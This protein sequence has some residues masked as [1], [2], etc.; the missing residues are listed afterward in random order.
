M[1]KLTEQRYGKA[2]VRVLY[3]PNHLKVHAKTALLK[4]KQG[5]FPQYTGLLSTGNLNEGTA[6]FYTDHI[7]LTSQQEMLKEVEMVFHSFEQ[8]FRERPKLLFTHLLVA[9]HNL[10]Q[11]F[12]EL[13]DREIQHARTGH[14]ARIV[15]KLNNL[16]ERVL[17]QKLYAASNAGVQIDLIVRSICCLVPGVP[18]LSENIRIRRIVDRFLE[19]GRV[20]LFHNQGRDDIYLGSADWM[21]RNIYSRIEVCFP[22]YDEALK[23]EL[24]EIIGL[25]LQDNVQAVAINSELQNVPLSANGTPLRSQQAIYMMLAAKQPVG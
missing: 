1:A 13:I 3:T 7:L 18:G 23:N 24:R 14:P 22:V 19:H 11:R 21:N 20:Y 25:Q 2:G 9:Q 17:I 10:Q 15:I 12:L 4:R 6:R 5:A 8:K 16:E